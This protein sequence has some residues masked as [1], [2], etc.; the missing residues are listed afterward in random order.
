[1]LMLPACGGFLKTKVMSWYETR[2]KE[3]QNRPLIRMQALG[4]ALDPD[5]LRGSPATK[6]TST[7]SW[8]ALWRCCYGSRSSG[9]QLSQTNPFGKILEPVGRAPP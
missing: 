7:A 9:P 1:M 6:S 8:N 4:E 5:R 2:R 3:L